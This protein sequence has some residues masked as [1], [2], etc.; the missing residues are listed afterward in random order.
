MTEIDLIDLYTKE[1]ENT[2]PIA[3]STA[4]EEIELNLRHKKLRKEISKHFNVTKESIKGYDGWK[5]D[6]VK[7]DD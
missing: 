7:L 2:C 6:V 4:T 3:I 1:P 5:T